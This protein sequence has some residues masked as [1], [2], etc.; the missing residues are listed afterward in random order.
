MV[1]FVTGVVDA[2]RIGLAGAIVLVNTGFFPIPHSGSSLHA[3]WG[4]C[5]FNPAAGLGD[6]CPT[7]CPLYWPTTWWPFNFHFS[8]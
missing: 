1:G 2:L 4:V 7:S 3:G 5:N 6:Y 8:L